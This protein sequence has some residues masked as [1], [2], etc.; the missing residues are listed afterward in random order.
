[1]SES[2]E[3]AVR[4]AQVSDDAAVIEGE[5]NSENAAEFESFLR[6]IETDSETIRLDLGGLD[7]EDGVALATAINALRELRARFSRVIVARAPQIVGHNLYR[8]GLLESIELVDMREDE[9]SG[10]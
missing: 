9:P 5:L 10:F 6:S 8:L 2:D 3:K 4:L 1:M 7:I